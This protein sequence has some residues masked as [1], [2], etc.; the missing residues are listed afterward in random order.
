MDEA[1]RRLNAAIETGTLAIV[2]IDRLQDPSLLATLQSL[3]IKGNDPPP[4]T[5]EQSPSRA[6]VQSCPAVTGSSP[7][8]TA[9]LVEAL[10]REQARGNV[11]ATK[12]AALTDEYHNLQSRHDRDAASAASKIS[13][14]QED[15]QQEREKGESALHELTGLRQEFSLLQVARETDATSAASK[16]AELEAA[17]QQERER[18]HAAAQELVRARGDFTTAQARHEREIDARN[19]SLSELKNAL[20]QEQA[21]SKTLSAELSNAINDVRKNRD[22]HET[23]PTPLMFR[24]EA[25]GAPDPIATDY[26]RRLAHA[27]QSAPFAKPARLPPGNNGHETA[28]SSSTSAGNP[29]PVVIDDRLV[30][31]ADAL[32]R[33]GDVSGARLLLERSMESG[34]ARAAFLL[35]E[36]FDPHVLSKLGVVGIRSDPAKARELYARALALGIQQA[37]S[38]MQALK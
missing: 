24:L 7:F 10:E 27:V 18:G 28:L 30:A 22:V 15:L 19:A 14:L 1:E 9:E 16:I 2:L 21:R 11:I 34:N 23:G 6:A 25:S 26:D 36:T 5:A 32:F 20:S 17:L 31:R 29:A 3:G 12:L 4:S 13:G 38:R 33:V 37:E 35:A 8:N